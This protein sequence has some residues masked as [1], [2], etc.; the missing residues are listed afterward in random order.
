ML[1]IPPNWGR[2][3]KPPPIEMRATSVPPWP[4][5]TITT[6]SPP[7]IAIRPAPLAMAKCT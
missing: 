7:V 2:L 3:P 5:A 4:G 6:S 1:P